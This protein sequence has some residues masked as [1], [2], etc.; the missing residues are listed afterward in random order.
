MELW[1]FGS[2]SMTIIDIWIYTYSLVYLVFNQLNILFFALLWFCQLYEILLCAMVDIVKEEY[3]FF[4]VWM[5]FMTKL[6]LLFFV[7]AQVAFSIFCLQNYSPQKSI[8]PWWK[9]GQGIL[10]QAVWLFSS[11]LLKCICII[12]A[13]GKPHNFYKVLFQETWT[14]PSTRVNWLCDFK[15]FT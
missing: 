9:F 11:V 3:C 15:V 13:V 7:I 6:I 8:F 14:G 5:N 10:H 1:L 12:C 2:P 4:G